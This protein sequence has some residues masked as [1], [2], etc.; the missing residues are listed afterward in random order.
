MVK[1]QAI[2]SVLIPLSIILV[3]LVA[4]LACTC[5]KLTGKKVSPWIDQR[6]KTRKYFLIK[7]QSEG[8]AE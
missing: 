1:I 6:W 2:S 4:V 3:I 5:Q 7:N 8:K